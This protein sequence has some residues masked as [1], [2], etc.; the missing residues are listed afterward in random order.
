MKKTLAIIAA[1]ALAT[2][3]AMAQ[4]GKT[5]NTGKTQVTP[6]LTETGA[7]VAD[8]T[9]NQTL[10]LRKAGAMPTEFKTPGNIMIVDKQGKAVPPANLRN[11]TRVHVYYT[12]S[13]DNKVVQKVVV[14]ENARLG[15]SERKTTE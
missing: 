14:D 4:W 9:P 12:G 8:Y 11:G 6:A 3:V 2:P 1:C 15:K 13:G 7:I 5:T 10:R